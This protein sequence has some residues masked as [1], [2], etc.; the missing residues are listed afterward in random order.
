MP[1]SAAIDDGLMGSRQR[2][3]IVV[4]GAG[5]GGLSA[6]IELVAS[7]FDVTLVERQHVPGGKMRE[8]EVGG[9]AVDSGPTVFTMR[10]VFEEL[11]AA[12]GDSLSGRVSLSA[13]DR[14]ARH[15]WLDGSRLDLY[16]DVEA[17]AAAIERFSS[18]TEA[19]SYRRFAAASADMFETL[20]HSF[21]R[22]ERP[23][24]VG[25]AMALGVGGIPRL[26][27]TR[28]F[29][30]MWSELGRYFDDPRLRQLF[31]RYAT[32][33]GSSPFDAPATLCLIA[34]AERAGVWLVDG[35]MQRLAE[36]MAAVLEERGA[37]LRYGEEVTRIVAS[38]GRVTGVALADGTTLDA[39][40]VVYNGDVAALS[41]GL[42]GSEVADAVPARRGEPRS[43]SAVTWSLRAD[44]AGYP[45]DHHTV[46]FGSDYAA[47]FDAIFGDGRVAAEPT[48]YVCAQDRGHGRE[49]AGGGAERLFMLV[50]APPRPLSDDDVA[51][52]AGRT[53][54]QLVRH[55]LSVS[56]TDDSAVVTTPGDYATRFP[57]SDGAIYG[58]PTHGWSGSFRRVGSRS[59]CDG[60]YL[61]G[62][63]VHPGPGVPMTAISGRL[64]AASV[65]ADLGR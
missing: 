56:V 23:G 15:S 30:S 63:T 38:G 1:R 54:A 46:F 26:V 18:A 3:D 47:E 40:A 6:A 43:L 29:V 10:W 58:W 65:V 24:P 34:H 61:A 52:I 41:Q 37:L 7:G 9:E 33:C 31:G 22:R 4:V 51:S 25:L 11:F 62:G 59:R 53:F 14:L 12:V 57:G 2:R 17:S 13:P 28:P 16:A 45:L 39:D 35:G 44:V 21:M 8:V 20:D 36:A 64:A 60:L 27:R 55:G 50:N 49:V 42:L 5:I 32:Y 48:V 19:D